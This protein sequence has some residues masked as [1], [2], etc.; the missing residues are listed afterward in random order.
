[1][2][3]RVWSLFLALALCL[4]MMPMAAMAEETGSGNVSAAGGEQKT[5]DLD[6]IDE[7]DGSIQKS[8]GVKRTGP[9]LTASD[10]TLSGKFYIVQGNITING[11]LTVD[12]SDNGGLLLAAFG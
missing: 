2:K 5:I 9:T 4:T 12:G 8:G 10:T 6:G 11:D 7:K 1:M 3:K